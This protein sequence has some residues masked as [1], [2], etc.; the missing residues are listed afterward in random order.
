MQNYFLVFKEDFILVA[1]T[2]K[3]FDTTEYGKSVTKY[4]EE[5]ENS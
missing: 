5:L 4:L 3:Q 1:H 2:H